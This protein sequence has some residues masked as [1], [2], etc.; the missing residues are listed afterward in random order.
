MRRIGDRIMV[1]RGTRV[2]LDRD[3]AELYGVSTKAL[4][5]AVARN[6]ARFPADF[7]FRLLQHEI[8]NLKSQ[9]GDG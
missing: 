8:R 3:L 6:G 4:N 7:A 5:Q 1:A 2:I 9:F